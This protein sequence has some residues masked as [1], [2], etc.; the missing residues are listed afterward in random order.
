MRLL[1]RSHKHDEEPIKNKRKLLF[2]GS[3]KERGKAQEREK[4]IP[5]SSILER[6]KR[7]V[8]VTERK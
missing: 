5:Q 1:P 7:F 6:G 3:F 4:E 8:V 2:H